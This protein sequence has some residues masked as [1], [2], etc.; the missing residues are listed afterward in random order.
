MFFAACLLFACTK[1]DAMEV[2][3]LLDNDTAKTADSSFEMI[4]IPS[5]DSQMTSFMSLYNVPGAS[6]AVTKNG[7]LVYAKGYGYAESAISD[8][9]DTASRFR[10][11]S[12]TKFITALGIMKLVEAGQV[13]LT[14][15]VFGTGALLDTVL[16]TRPYP[17]YVEDITVEHLLRH[18]GGGWGNSSNDP[19][20]AQSALNIDQLIGWAIDNRPL[21]HAPGTFTDYSNLGYMILG[22]IIEKVS[23]QTYVNFIS[24]NV[25]LPAGVTNMEIGSAT[26]AGRKVNEVKY[27]GQGGQNPYGY[28]TSAFTRLGPAGSWIA[29]PID[30]MRIMVHVDGFS[31]VPDILLPAT[32]TTMS[33]PSAISNYAFGNRIS[34]VYKNWWHSGSLAGTFTWRVRTYHGYCWAIL[35]NTRS[36]NSSFGNAVDQLIWPAINSSATVWP[37]Y[38]LF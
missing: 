12:L 11:A 22:R 18:E 19:A 35:L 25:L 13:S 32:I 3:P 30:L 37:S 8:P 38:D 7:K 21:A 31:T 23:G 4:S 10:I 2:L 26:L 5:I 27:Y 29:S 6:V 28:N 33:T 34:N 1:K 17:A 20:F 9:V 16:G 36:T 24:Q 14:D 15:K